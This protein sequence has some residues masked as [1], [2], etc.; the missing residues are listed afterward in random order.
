MMIGVKIKKLR[1][2]NKVTQEQLAKYLN[3]TPQAVSKWEKNLAYSEIHLLVPIANYFS[4]TVDYL[5]R[6]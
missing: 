4:V 2:K 3:V 5:L 6:D 1:R